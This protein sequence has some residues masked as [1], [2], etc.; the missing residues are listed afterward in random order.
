[1]NR[2]S[3]RA[4][5]FHKDADYLAFETVLEQAVAKF[6]VRLLTYILMPNH[7]HLVLCPRRR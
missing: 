3:A 7:F 2:A 5:I 1:M 4:R 6:N